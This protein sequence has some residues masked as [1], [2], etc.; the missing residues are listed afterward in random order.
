MS[1]LPTWGGFGCN[2]NLLT[3]VAME[4][5]VFKKSV[6]YCYNI[7]PYQGWLRTYNSHHSKIS[8][9]LDM[10]GSTGQDTFN[11]HRDYGLSQVLIMEGHIVCFDLRMKH[12]RCS[13]WWPKKE[14]TDIT[15]PRSIIYYI[16]ALEFILSLIIAPNYGGIL[17]F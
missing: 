17:N 13:F 2:I 14:C 8:L 5:Q 15:I 6:T 10:Q 4:Y 11:H 7:F 12:L 1:S 16:L 3:H 9:V